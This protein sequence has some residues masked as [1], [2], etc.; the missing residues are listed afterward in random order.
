[1]R[2]IL[3]I[4]LCVVVKLHAVELFMDQFHGLQNRLVF[5]V[6]RAIDIQESL[7]FGVNLLDGTTKEVG[8]HMSLWESSYRRYV[9][10][11]TSAGIFYSFGVRG[12]MVNLTKVS[13]N[14]EQEL[15][16][17]PF[18]DIGIKGQLS[19]RWFHVLRLEAGY[20]MLYSKQINIDHILGLQF[21]PF[22]SFGYNLD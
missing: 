13:E 18:Y 6:E 11:T 2:R 4:L 1:M 21:T 17:M 15:C 3:F 10:E 5:R 9:S 22:F 14:S 20:F 16:V 19:K 8:F 7:L 12:G